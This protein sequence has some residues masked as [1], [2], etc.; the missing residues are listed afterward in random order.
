MALH[1]TASSSDP[2]AS[3]SGSGSCQSGFR[4]ELPDLGVLLISPGGVT[5]TEPSISTSAKSSPLL[6][7]TDGVGTL[8]LFSKRADFLSGYFSF[9]I[10]NDIRESLEL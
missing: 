10:K 9:L 5:K 3:P 6:G 7:E 4:S 8:L 2:V 1:L